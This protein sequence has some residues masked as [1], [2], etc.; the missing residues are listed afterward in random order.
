LLISTA[1]E[2]VGS[3]T[4]TWTITAVPEPGSLVPLVLAALAMGRRRVS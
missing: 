2:L 1:D 4:Y 3:D